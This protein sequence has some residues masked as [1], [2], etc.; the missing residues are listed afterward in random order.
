MARAFSPAFFALPTW[1]VAP[2]RDRLGLGRTGRAPTAQFIPARAE[3]PASVAETEVEQGR[4]AAHRERITRFEP[5]IHASL[6]RIWG[7]ATG[8]GGVGTM[9]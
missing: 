4:V 5:K 2:S 6:A 9:Q 3:G 7:E 8:E 1:G